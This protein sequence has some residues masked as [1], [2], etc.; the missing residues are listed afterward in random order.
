[1]EQVDNKTGRDGK[2]MQD[3]KA[4][5]DGSDQARGQEAL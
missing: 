3:S 4:C 1:M 2:A 5:L